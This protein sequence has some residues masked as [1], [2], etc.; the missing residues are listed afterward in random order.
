LH[1]GLAVG[2]VRGEADGEVLLHPDESIVAAIRAVFDRFA[3]MG[4]A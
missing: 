4:S 1:H 3:E 2:L